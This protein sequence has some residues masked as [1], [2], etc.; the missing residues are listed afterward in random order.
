MIVI[1]DNY[2]L[3]QVV[4]GIS[5]MSICTASEENSLFLGQGKFQLSF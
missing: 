1:P 5:H 2:G 3:I 4:A